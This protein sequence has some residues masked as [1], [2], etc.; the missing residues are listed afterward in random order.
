MQRIL[1]ALFVAGGACAALG[2]RAEA[3]PRQK[4]PTGASRTVAVHA[5][6][7][8][9]VATPIEV[10]LT[11]PKGFAGAVV[12]A[13]GR[14]VPCQVTPRGGKLAV[15]WIVA[16]L[17]RGATRTY[18]V[19][20]TKASR[21]KAH[22]VAR[23][24][25]GTEPLRNAEIT[26]G[27]SLFARYDVNTGPNKPYFHPVYAPGQR[28]V[29]RGYPVAPRA[30]E[31]SD[32]KH[33]RG[34]WFTHGSVN[35]EDFWAE[36]PSKTVHAGYRDITGGPVFAGFTAL[37][38]WIGKAGNKIAEDTRQV[39]VFELAGAR[40]MD[41][42]IVMRPV[43]GPLV[44]GDTKEGSFGLRLADTMR[45]RGG[46]GR[47]VN[48]A[49]VSGG[50]TWGKRAPWVDYSGTAD[51]AQV[52]VAILEHPTSFRHPTWWHVRDYGLFCANPFGV[53]DF[54]SG[55]P[56]GAGSHTVQPGGSLTLAYRLIFHE[57]DAD[58]AQIARRWDEWAN[59][60]TVEIVK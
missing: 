11:P 37:T 1:I 42:R 59:P 6:K 12:S 32:H 15:C 45:L 50:E 33:H 58:Q 38:D 26:V 24:M 40:V 49:G 55:K 28:Q 43:G 31:T 52:G 29:V 36:T 53:H 4:P 9:C 16:D 14:S 56:A 44:F 41:V 5:E 10:A 35:G 20:F 3:A 8:A 19:T 17:P 46:E 30:G 21:S 39:R 47:I 34:L 48:G 7:A 25:P 13:S 22:I 2:L 60:P 18:T 27:G 54:E 23:L 51:G 57:G